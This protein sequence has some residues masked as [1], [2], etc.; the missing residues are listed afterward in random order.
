MS[1]GRL[2]LQVHSPIIMSGGLA[3]LIKT[4]AARLPCASV[5]RWRVMQRDLAN[6]YD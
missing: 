5:P 3:R 2:I 6:Q 1:W 4:D